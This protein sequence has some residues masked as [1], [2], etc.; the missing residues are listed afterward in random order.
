MQVGIYSPLDVDQALPKRQDVAVPSVGREVDHLA[1]R[2][3]MSQVKYIMQARIRLLRLRLVHPEQDR[4]LHL[5]PQP[6]LL[7][8]AVEYLVLWWKL[9]QDG[10]IVADQPR[11]PCLPEKRADPRILPVN[12]AADPAAVDEDVGRVDVPMPQNGRGKCWVLR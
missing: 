10:A 11:L 7:V 6:V 3:S 9:Q 4:A 2:A 1:P 5:C 8:L 12:Y